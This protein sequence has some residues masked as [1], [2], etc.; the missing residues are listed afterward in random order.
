MCLIVFSYRERSGFPLILAANRDEFYARPA[1]GLGPWGDAPDIIAGRDEVGGGTW[2][3]LTRRGRFAAVTNYREPRAVREH[4][5]SRGL[6]VADYL[7]GRDAPGVYMENLRKRADR[8]SG[9]SLLAGDERELYYFCNIDNAVRNLSPG[10]YGVSNH[11]LDTPW[12][13]VRRAK[14]ALNK[15]V[16]ADTITSAELLDLLTDTA[17]ADTQELPDTGVGL[18]VERELSPIFIAGETYGTRASTAL[19]I[20]WDGHVSITERAHPDGEIRSLQWRL[21]GD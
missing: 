12:P 1:A 3:G 17:P 5:P 11:L 18:R 13:K 20:A 14:C 19:T 9:F 16:R 7:R 21:S 2:L 15:L 10:T 4:A 6:L 8:Y